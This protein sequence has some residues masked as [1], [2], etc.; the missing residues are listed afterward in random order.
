MISPGLPALKY[1][2]DAMY[3]LHDPTW[4]KQPGVFE[5]FALMTQSMQI[6]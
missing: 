1:W 6:L 5:I 4:Q 3:V 2:H